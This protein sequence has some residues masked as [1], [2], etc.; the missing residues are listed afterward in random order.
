MKS[1][2]IFALAVV[3][4]LALAS[5]AVAG[6]VTLPAMGQGGVALVLADWQGPRQ[7]PPRFRNHCSVD[8][9]SG[10]WY[11][12]DHCGIDYHVYYCSPASFGCCHIGRG[13]CGWNG[14]LH[15]S[16]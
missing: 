9:L 8:R 1:V 14:V 13:Y 12:S 7:L 6:P 3:G 15:C 5:V 2:K 16:P 4:L 11:C 10:R